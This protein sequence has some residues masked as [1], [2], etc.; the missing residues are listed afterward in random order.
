MILRRYM[1]R[2]WCRRPGRTLLTL[3]GIVIGV[4]SLVA[5]PLSIQ[6]TRRTHRELFESLTGKAVLEVVPCGQGGFSPALAAGLEEMKDV[7]AVV[8][9]IQSAAAIWGPSGFVGVMTLGID[10]RRDDQARDYVLRRGSLLEDDGQVLLEDA[11]AQSLGLDVNS[12]IRLLSPSGVTELRLVGLLAPRGAAAVNGGAVAIMPLKTAQHLYGL[13]GEVNNLNLVL[14]EGADRE[15]VAQ[16]VSKRLPPG[17]TVQAPAARAILAQETMASAEKLL[18]A[19]SIASLVAGA[20][21]ILNSFLM[22]LGERRHALAILRSLGATRTQVT[23]LLIFEAFAL[24]VVG[25]VV[26]IPVGLAGAFAMAQLMA[27]MSGSIAPQL[28]ITA[29]PIVLAGLLGPGV[30]M[31]ATYVPSRDAGASFAAGRIA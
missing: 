22:S 17:L 14:E 6:T 8:P 5:I 7:R 29:G 4:Q 30:A 3:L 20:F 13:D 19:L 27:Q 10:T 15:R 21:V 16:E 26:G 11:Y 12:T 2:E 1:F 9:I 28:Q 23:R 18:A 24:G 25:T 31:L